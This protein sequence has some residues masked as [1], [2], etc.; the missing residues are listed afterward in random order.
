VDT[1]DELS[2]IP[3]AIVP[4]KMEVFNPDN[5]LP[6]GKFHIN[7]GFEMW[8]MDLQKGETQFT[9]KGK[10]ERNKVLFSING[11]DFDLD[12]EIVS[13]GIANLD[14]SCTLQGFPSLCLTGN[15]ELQNM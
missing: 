1:N 7:K 2:K 3:V 5:K 10:V 13:V 9:E 11:M 4:V 12:G 6:D 8:G 14:I 15:A